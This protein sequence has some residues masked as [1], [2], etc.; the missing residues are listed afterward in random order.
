VDSKSGPG[1]FYRLGAI[2]AG[3]KVRITRADT[4]VTTFVVDKVEAF[5]KDRFPA[6]VY[7]GDFTRAEI[8]LITCGGTF[9]RGTGHYRD[10]IVVFGHLTAA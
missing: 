8:R 4:S 10:N 1:V 5:P 2:K 9:D 6:D 7:T 3:D